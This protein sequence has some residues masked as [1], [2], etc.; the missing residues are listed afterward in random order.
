MLK[1]IQAQPEH[2]RQKISFVLTLVIFVM[3][4][5]IWLSSWGARTA[6][7][8]SRERTA[9][10]LE[11]VKEIFSGTVSDVKDEIANAPFL[12]EYLHL[13]EG[14][15]STAE[16]SA[17]EEATSSSPIFDAS[18][19]VIIDRIASTTKMDGR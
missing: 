13:K 15:I 19:V 16:V 12:G 7:E 2:V 10:P 14:G 5:F 6:S 9:S 4:F 3:I 8:D 11:S 1:K 17:G 18:G